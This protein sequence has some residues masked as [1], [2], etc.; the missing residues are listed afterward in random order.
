VKIDP[1]NKFANESFQKPPQTALKCK[2]RWP[3]CEEA[4]RP[5]LWVLYLH[6]PY[7][8]PWT[9]VRAASR[10]KNKSRH[11][12]HR[13]LGNSGWFLYLVSPNN[14]TSQS[15]TVINHSMVMIT[16]SMVSTGCR[17]RTTP[18]VTQLT[19]LSHSSMP[20]KSTNK[21]TK[22]IIWFGY[23]N[24]PESSEDDPITHPSSLYITSLTDQP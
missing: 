22:K 8:C 6:K 21:L 9:K 13:C 15:D 16:C 4:S 18:S 12:C 11:L 5:L 14:S 2:I 7:L 24:R 10:N 19:Q 23:G 1:A 3:A 20:S 17:L